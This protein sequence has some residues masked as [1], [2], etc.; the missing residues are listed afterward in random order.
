VKILQ[1]TSEIINAIN[2]WVG[3]LASWLV[4]LMVMIGGWNVV[5]RFIGRWTEQ[6]LSSNALIETQWYLYA[7]IFLLGAAYTL[8]H[9]AHVRVDVFHRNWPPKWKAIAE[10]VGTLLFLIPFCSLVIFFSWKPIL[11]SWKISEV[12]PDPDGLPRYP[13]KSIILVGFSLLILQG[14]STAI[15]N[16]ILLNTLNS[17]Q[18]ESHNRD[19]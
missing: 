10:L 1:R 19:T 5:G 7:L 15:Q 18:E 8:K 2:E 3:R 11:N 14:I 17:S 13:I 16:I 9:N 6:S 4:L 12:S